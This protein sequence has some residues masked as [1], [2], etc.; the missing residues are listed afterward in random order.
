MT[1]RTAAAMLP[2]WGEKDPGACA[3]ERI[4]RIGIQRLPM[5]KLRLYLVTCRLCGTTL[6]TRTLRDQRDLRKGKGPAATP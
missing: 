6:T 5:G 4:E 1:E 3:H 2:R